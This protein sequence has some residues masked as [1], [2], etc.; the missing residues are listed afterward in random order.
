MF[1][2]IFRSK[3]FSNPEIGV[4]SAISPGDQFSS[5]RGSPNNQIFELF[6]LAKYDKIK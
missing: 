1:R 5:D 4:N 3:Q 2:L 6:E